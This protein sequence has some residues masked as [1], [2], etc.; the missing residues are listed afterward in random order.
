MA[1]GLLSPRGG[2]G[3]YGFA[4][5]AKWE[6][7]QSSEPITFG[8]PSKAYSCRPCDPFARA[9]PRGLIPEINPH[10]AKKDDQLPGSDPVR[11]PNGPSQLIFL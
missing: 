4:P 5:E 1:A 11:R 7:S 9:V 2:Y 6:R 8:S 3:L 10:I